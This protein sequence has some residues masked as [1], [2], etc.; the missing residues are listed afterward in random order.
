MFK[1]QYNCAHFSVSKVFLKILQSRLQQYM[2]WELPDVQ[3]GLQRGRET[4]DQIA[5]ICWIVEKTRE[6]HKNICFTDYAK[7][8]DYVNHNK[9]WEFLK[10]MEVSDHLTY[11][12]RNLLAGQEATVR[13]GHGKT[14]WFIIGKG[15]QQGCIL[16]P[17]LFLIC[18]VHHVK[19]WTGWSTS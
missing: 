2:N 16:S 12:L 19:C 13:M 7:T 1:V 18:R 15:V 3:D 8:F 5:N 14:D 11:L 9:L 10:E 4:R 17:C 6:F